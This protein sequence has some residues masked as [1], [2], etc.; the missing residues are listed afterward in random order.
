MLSAMSYAMSNRMRFIGLAFLLFASAATAQTDLDA[1]HLPSVGTPRPAADV[2]SQSELPSGWSLPI[3]RGGNLFFERRL[4]GEDQPSIF[5][6]RTNMAAL[7]ATATSSNPAP[8]KDQRLVDP[9][10]LSR[11]VR[12]SIELADVSRDGSLVAYRLRTAGAEL[13]TVRVFN[14]KSGKSLEDELPAGSYRSINFTPDGRGLFYTRTNAQGTLLYLHRFGERNSRD[15]LLFGHEF[16]GE[17][18][19]PNDLFSAEVTDDA[20]YL[21]VEIDRGIPAKR[22]D[23]VFRDLTKPGSPFEVLVWDLD[24]RFSAIYA[25]GAWFV[26]TDYKSPDSRILKA[27][28]GILPDVWKIIVPESPEPIQNFSIVG[29]KLFI[30]QLKDAKPEISVYLLNGRP[31]ESI[32]LDG[33]GTVTRVSGSV[34]SRYGFFSFQPTSHS[35]ILYR[36]DTI[37]GKRDVFAEPKILFEI[38]SHQTVQNSR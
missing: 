7:S 1:P 14:V 18:L 10:A 29:D 25:K 15:T 5:L 31:T 20:R 8:N 3:E 21:V 6:R 30:E 38:G 24:A 22:V 2:Q 19:G 28:P 33:T 36:L 26:K 13:S 32:Q 27:D 12:T 16:R 4:T 11:D 9:A 34:G 17:L 37:T 23:I 35:P